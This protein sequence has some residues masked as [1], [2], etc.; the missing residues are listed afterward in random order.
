L[1]VGDALHVNLDTPGFYVQDGTTF[2]LQQR[3]SVVFVSADHDR[4]FRT[5]LAT[6]QEGELRSAL[7]DSLFGIDEALLNLLA[8]NRMRQKS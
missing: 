5:N 6:A 8:T 2:E 7:E 4:N 1:A 3:D